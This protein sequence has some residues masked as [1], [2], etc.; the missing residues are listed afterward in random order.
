[1]KEY[2]KAT[3]KVGKGAIIDITFSSNTRFM[4]TS[5]SD[6]C[7]SVFRCKVDASSSNNV[8]SKLSLPRMGTAATE[9][10]LTAK[11]TSL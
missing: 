2:S 5:D 10:P 4:A 8:P 3:T 9:E 1:M 6:N 11:G 7:V